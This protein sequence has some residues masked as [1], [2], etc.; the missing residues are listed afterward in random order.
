MAYLI[1]HPRS[2]IAELLREHDTDELHYASKHAFMGQIGRELA[3]VRVPLIEGVLPGEVAQRHLAYFHEA[4]QRIAAR[5]VAGRSGI[6]WLWYLRRA[7]QL[8]ELNRLR[9]TRLYCSSI[10]EQLCAG[11]PTIGTILDVHR[12]SLEASDA[13]DLLYL[14]QAVGQ[15]YNVHSAIRWAGKDSEIRFSGYA[16]PVAEP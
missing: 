2:R 14:R 6:E 9:G 8:F 16:A 11:S 5:F 1:D 12:F 3:A 13:Y 10:A 4:A 7:P 15:I